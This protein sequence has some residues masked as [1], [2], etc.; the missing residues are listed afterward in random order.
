M[1]LVIDLGVGEVIMKI[2]MKEVK[3]N[4][5][6]TVEGTVILVVIDR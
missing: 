1:I 3:V 2:E 4:S 6:E 5:V